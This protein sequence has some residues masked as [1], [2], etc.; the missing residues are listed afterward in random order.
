MGVEES[1]SCELEEVHQEARLKKEDLEERE[2]D[3]T[4]TIEINVRFRNAIF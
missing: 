4:L 1:W 3:L 2:R